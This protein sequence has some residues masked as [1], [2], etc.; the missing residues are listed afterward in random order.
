MLVVVVERHV[1]ATLVVRVALV[2]VV[3][4]IVEYQV[5]AAAQVVEQ[6]ILVLVVVVHN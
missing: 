1:K 2:V 4:G 6:P 5:Q 3:E